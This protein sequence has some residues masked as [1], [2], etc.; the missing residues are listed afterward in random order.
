MGIERARV[1][2]LGLE[3]FSV[4][5]FLG[6]VLPV[7]CWISLGISAIRKPGSQIPFPNDTRAEDISGLYTMPTESNLIHVI[8]VMIQA[9][10]PQSHTISHLRPMHQPNLC[11]PGF[12]FPQPFANTIPKPQLDTFR[13]GPLN[14][15]PIKRLSQC[16]HTPSNPHLVR[17]L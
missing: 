8:P 5:K 15:P 16:L 10:P 12:P 3:I 17:R 1:Q 13:P 4:S 2:F 6:Q 11:F 14:I 7:G 9:D